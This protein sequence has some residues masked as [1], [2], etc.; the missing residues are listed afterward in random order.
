MIPLTEISQ[1]NVV[2]GCE[3]R[4]RRQLLV[5]DT[6][7]ELFEQLYVNVGCIFEGGVQVF[8]VLRVRLPTLKK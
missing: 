5:L 3:N 6:P 2:V 7:T 8:D 1:F 4:A